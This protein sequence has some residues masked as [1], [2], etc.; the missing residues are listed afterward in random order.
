LTEGLKFEIGLK[1][2]HVLGHFMGLITVSIWGNYLRV[3]N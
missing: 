1:F 2:E 3:G